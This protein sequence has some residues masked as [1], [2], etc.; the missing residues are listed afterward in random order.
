[1]PMKLVNLLCWTML[2]DIFW[3]FYQGFSKVYRPSK[4]S[5]APGRGLS[6]RAPFWSTECAP[7]THQNEGGMGYPSAD[8]YPAAVHSCT[9]GGFIFKFHEPEDRQALRQHS[10]LGAHGDLIECY[11]PD[12]RNQNH[13]IPL[14]NGDSFFSN[15]SFPTFYGNSQ[16][17]I[18]LFFSGMPFNDIIQTN[19]I[20]PLPQNQTHHCH[21]L[22][23]HSEEKEVF[24]IWR[25]H[26]S[27][28]LSQIRGNRVSHEN[29]L[30]IQSSVPSYTH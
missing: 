13:Q 18:Y 22:Y 9:R 8:W 14:K 4:S 20:F 7:A 30:H 23:G 15:N 5:L 27:N 2:K 21:G 29:T 26:H 19:W 3:W 16:W 24:W 28:S 17:L 10:L 25:P 1:M 12:L 6:G 11:P